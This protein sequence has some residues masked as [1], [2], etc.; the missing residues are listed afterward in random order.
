MSRGALQKLKSRSRYEKR[1]KVVFCTIS[2]K[3]LENR[4]SRFETKISL[5][6]FSRGS[7]PPLNG[8]NGQNLNPGDQHCDFGFPAN[9]KVAKG[10]VQP[11]FY[12]RW[13]QLCQVLR[14]SLLTTIFDKFSG[15][16]IVIK[17]GIFLEWHEHAAFQIL[18]GINANFKPVFELLIRWP[19]N[20][21]N[22]FSIFLRLDRFGRFGKII[23]SIFSKFWKFYVFFGFQEF[24]RI[25]KF[26]EIFFL[27]YY[28]NFP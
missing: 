5:I 3:G 16:S 24:L 8:S 20:R 27:V 25:L 11:M 19:I 7:G 23:K 13:P 10:I 14:R 4:S 9:I 26:R 18:Q 22:R 2:K 6:S 17:F 12:K 21:S 1:T 15:I 28:P